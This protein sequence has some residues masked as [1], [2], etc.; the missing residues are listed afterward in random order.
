MKLVLLATIS[1]AVAV[2]GGQSVLSPVHDRFNEL[3]DRLRAVDEDYEADGWFSSSSDSWLDNVDST[4]F[5]DSF[6]CFDEESVFEMFEG[7]DEMDDV[8][9]AG[10]LQPDHTNHT[11]SSSMTIYQLIKGSQFTTKMAAF[12]DADP[13]N[14]LART[15]DD[16]TM[17][18]TIFV[19]TDSAFEKISKNHP[20]LSPG[21]VRKMLYYHISSGTTHL[22]AHSRDTTIPTLY[23]EPGLGGDRPQRLS[24]RPDYEGSK[25]VN[26][27]ARVVAD[28]IVSS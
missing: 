25:F 3:D 27:Y 12:I 4:M 2:L 13:D 9:T 5:G 15:L 19:P 20:Q 18:H 22:A 8:E 24:I 10:N 21:A 14:E 11:A 23:K 7:K 6:T 16:P 17:K 1:F 26:S 28:D